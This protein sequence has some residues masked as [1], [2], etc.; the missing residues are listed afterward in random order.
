MECLCHPQRI[1]RGTMQTHF[2]QFSTRSG[3]PPKGRHSFGFPWGPFFPCQ[4]LLSTL[5]TASPHSA[6]DRSRQ[7]QRAVLPC[8]KAVSSE[9]STDRPT[10]CGRKTATP[11]K[12]S[13]QKRK[14]F[15]LWTLVPSLPGGT[16]FKADLRGDVFPFFAMVRGALLHLAA[17]A[18]INLDWR[19]PGFGNLPLCLVNQLPHSLF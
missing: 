9:T 6:Q 11:S 1:S 12:K 18:N 13:F 3:E 10:G 15:I 16:M 19:G 14:G 4:G 17:G 5:T 8:A 7:F 2:I